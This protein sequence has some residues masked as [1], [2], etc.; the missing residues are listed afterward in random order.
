MQQLRVSE[1]FLV[2]DQDIPFVDEHVAALPADLRKDLAEKGRSDL[3]FFAKGILSYRDMAVGCHRPACRFLNTNPAQFKLILWPRDHFKSSVVTIGGTMQ[4]V[5][6]NPES[7]SLIRNE[8]ATNAQRFLRTIRQHAEG[9]RIF[10]ALYSEVIPKDMKKVRWNDSELDFI[11]QGQ[12]PEPTVSA[13]G[14]TSTSTSQ[15]FTH[16]TDDDPISEEAIKSDL[17]MQE[18]INRI[19][20]VDALMD[21]NHGSH[22]LVGTRWSFADT[23]SW[24]EKTF[25]GRM[26]RY[27]RG[28]IEDGLPMFPERFTLEKLAAIRDTV[29][30]YRWSCN[31]MNNPRNSEIQD[32]NVEDLRFWRWNESGDRVLLFDR[33]GQVCDNWRLDEL[34]V[35]ITVD[36]APAET[37]TSDRN[38]ISVVGVSPRNQMVVLESFAERCTPLVLIDTLIAYTKKYGPRKIGIEKA[39]YQMS[40]KWFL[41]DRAEAEGI[42]SRVEPLRPG[43]KGKPH[44]RGLQPIMAVGRLYIPPGALLLRQEMA[45]YPLGEHDDAVDALGLQLQLMKGQLS[46]EYLGKMKAEENKILKSIHSFHPEEAQMR[47]AL[48]LDPDEPFDPEMAQAM[49]GSAITESQLQ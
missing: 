19:K 22:W 17:V 27:I 21:P 23:Y 37:I 45:D 2:A 25:K 42:Y 48:D 35:T 5:V 28:A 26:A 18:A 49:F 15:H 8:I 6:Q 40:L 46:P 36:P 32:L 43:G 29:Q 16:I 24:Y 20:G 1:R 4:R 3:Y 9:N 30:E 10:R 44:V 38:A 47:A 41:K 34:D 31:Y 12:Y 11:R 14:I 39:T 13:A 7:R 33:S